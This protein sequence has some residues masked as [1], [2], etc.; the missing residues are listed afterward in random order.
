MTLNTGSRLLKPFVGSLNQE[1]WRK[2]IC[3]RRLNCFIEVC[4][5]SKIPK[6]LL[7]LIEC[8]LEKSPFPFLSLRK[9]FVNVFGFP[10]ASSCGDFQSGLIEQGAAKQSPLLS[11]ESA[12]SLR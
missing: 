10:A 12:A 3:Q 9:F 5:M 7:M 8:K 4:K 6:Q 11:Q 1:D 2:W